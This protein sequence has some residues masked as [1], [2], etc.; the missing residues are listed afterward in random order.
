MSLPILNTPEYTT[1]VP[2]TKQTIKFR[3]FLVKEEKLLFMALQGGDQKEMTNAVSKI[4][5]ACVQTED[6][7]I[8]KLAMF[9]VEYLFLQL[10]GKSVGESV[11]LTLRHGKDNDCKNVV[12]VSINL[13]QINV[14]FP[15]D[16]SD[17][18][19]LTDEVGMKMQF[20]GVKHIS[21]MGN[22]DANSQDFDDLLKFIS[23]CVVCIYD[24]DNVYDSFTNDEIKNFLESLDQHQFAK[25]QKYFTNIPKL[26]HDIEWTCDKCG[27]TETIHLE[28]LASF[29]T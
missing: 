28:G 4:I 22:I 2:S 14:E 5:S 6:F 12:N 10:R 17:K 8:D 29:F 27:K 9:D 26:Q 15:E 21:E 24:N 19:Q 25:V 3:P 18:I 16:Y 7:N 1:T 20:P 23:S 13:D 11:D